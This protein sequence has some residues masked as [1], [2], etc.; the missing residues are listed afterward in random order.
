MLN[1]LKPIIKTEAMVFFGLL[2]FLTVIMHNDLLTSPL[3]R[4]ELMYEVGNYTHPFTYTFFVYAI[5]LVFRLVFGLIFSL[6]ESKK[7]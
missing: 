4:I 2:L 3:V 7:K 1:K 5:I 6:F